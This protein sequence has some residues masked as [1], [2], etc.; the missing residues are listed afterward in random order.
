MVLVTGGSGFLGS[1][2]IDQLLLQ[3]I[4]VRATRR[5]SSRIPARLLDRHG[6]EWVEADLLDYFALD[7][8]FDG[9]TQVYHCAAHVSYHPAHRSSM[10]DIN[11][12]GTAQVVNLCLEHQ[13]RL[14]HVSSIAA[15]GGSKEG[16]ATTEMDLW[17]YNPGLSA[18]SIAKYESEMEVWRGFSEGLKGII[19]NP[20]LIIGASAGSRGSGAVFH[21]LA[22]GLKYYPGGSV[23]LVDVEDVAKAM[24]QL[25][26]REDLNEERFIISHL[27]MSHQDLLSQCSVNLQLAAPKTKATPLM[28]ELAWRFSKLAERFTGK[29]AA[30]TKESAR[31]SS[32]KLRFSNAKLVNTLGFVF[33]P[34]DQTLQEICVQ[35][36][37]AQQKD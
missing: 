9:V 33:K 15:L 1:S 23:G 11:V 32:K 13:A 20:S 34:M 27:N 19:V 4:P 25:M 36:L 30:L 22:K 31:V 24:I 8:A 2:L 26:Q 16:T 10:M 6:L 7:S 5:A 3:G 28:L 17:E 21:L 37:S 18:Y 14:V 35:V 29:R 12:K